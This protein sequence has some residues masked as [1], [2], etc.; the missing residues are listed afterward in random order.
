MFI[1]GITLLSRVIIANGVTSNLD[2][3]VFSTLYN[4]NVYMVVVDPKIMYFSPF[5]F[6]R[7]CEAPLSVVM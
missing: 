1:L 7:W 5:Y 2:T 3:N 6:T 4:F